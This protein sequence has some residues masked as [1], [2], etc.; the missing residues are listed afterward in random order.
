MIILSFFFLIFTASLDTKFSKL[1]THSI[2]YCTIC[3]RGIM[4]VLGSDRAI[5]NLVG[6]ERWD[7]EWLDVMER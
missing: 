7:Y 4:K 5:K 1:I 6:D 2:G 3:N